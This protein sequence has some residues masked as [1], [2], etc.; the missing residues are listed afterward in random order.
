MNCVWG[1]E[2]LIKHLSRVISISYDD[3]ISSKCH[4]FKAKAQVEFILTIK[5]GEC[6]V[7]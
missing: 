2:F 7:L 3:R 1:G 5:G 6:E 4:Q